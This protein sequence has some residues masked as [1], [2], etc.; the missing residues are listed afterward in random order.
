MPPQNLQAERAVLGCQILDGKCIEAVQAI[1]EPSDFYS[2]VHATIQRAINKCLDKGTDVLIV[3]D[4]LSAFGKLDEIG[5]PGYLLECLESVPHSAHASYYAGVVAS[6]SR[7]RKAMAIGR[8]LVDNASDLTKDDEEVI[9]SAHDSAMKMAELLRVRDTQPRPVSEHVKESIIKLSQ[10][11]APTVYWTSPAVDE[12]VGGLALTELVIIAAGTSQGKTLTAMQMLDEASSRGI[13]GMI[14]SEEMS[15]A[16][17]ASRELCRMTAVPGVD[18]PKATEILERDRSAWYQ[19]RAPLLVAEKCSTI[20]A[21]ERAVNRAVE[22]HGIKIVAVDY[23]QLLRGEGD[24]VEQQIGDVSTKM[25]TLATKHN[26]IVLLLSQLN[27]GI[28]GRPDPTPQ[29]KDLRG[30]GRLEQDAD[31]VLFPFWPWKIDD[32]Y[33][34]KSEYRIYVRK[35]RNRGIRDSVVEMRID[36]ARQRIYPVQEQL[37]TGPDDGFS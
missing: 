9:Q 15:A 37:F 6:H 21:A 14:I 26:I 35:N 33:E 30:S 32:T 36:P 29:L 25:K 3:A 24:T 12:L 5:G 4:E 17:L 34:N 8:Q 11:V 28:D 18:W 27:R 22:S 16:L 2:D 1:I 13:P 20:A 19:N 10:G 23:A 31:I 7:R